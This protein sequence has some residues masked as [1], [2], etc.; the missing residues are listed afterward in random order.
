[1]D[2]Q[3]PTWHECHSSRTNTYEKLRQGLS[4]ILYDELHGLDDFR[5]RPVQALRQRLQVPAW[6][7]SPKYMTNLCRQLS[8]IEGRSRLCSAAR[9]EFDVAREKLSTFGRRV[10]SYAGQSVGNSLPNYL[11][12]SSFTLAIFKRSLKTFWFSKH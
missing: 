4:R 7:I 8:A 1:M 11:K 6:H 9:G 12:D 10:F 2:R 3:T 5:A